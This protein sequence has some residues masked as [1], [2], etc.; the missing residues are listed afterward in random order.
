V[1]SVGEGRTRSVSGKNDARSTTGLDTRLSARPCA[2]MRDSALGRSRG[3]TEDSGERSLGESTSTIAAS[4]PTSGNGYPPGD[5]GAPSPTASESCSVRARIS[6]AVGCAW[7][8]G[9]A[10][11]GESDSGVRYGLVEKDEDEAK[12]R[13]ARSLRSRMSI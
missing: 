4:G 11:V 7:W 12:E 1:C 8:A 3:V 13:A 2:I 9:P 5:R 10:G 6:S